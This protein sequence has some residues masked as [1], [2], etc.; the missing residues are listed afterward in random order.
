MYSLL[1]KSAALIVLQLLFVLTINAQQDTIVTHSG[2]VIYGKIL[3]ES[4]SIV[5]YRFSSTDGNVSYQSLSYSSIKRIGYF[6][7]KA[8]DSKHD[9]MVG[10]GFGL[11]YGGIGLNASWYISK[12][13]RIMISG[14][15]VAGE[16]GF[17][18]G[19]TLRSLRLQDKMK[20]IPV[21]IVMYGYNARAFDESLKT[22]KL[23]YGPTI[24]GGLEYYPN[25]AKQR[26]WTFL[27]LLPFRSNEEI[28]RYQ[29]EWYLQ[30]KELYHT[31]TW[32]GISVGYNF[33]VF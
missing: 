2:E 8:L 11:Y 3:N 32:F 6:I 4:D 5:R 15:H 14:G 12:N 23:F 29:H 24:G 16:N 30:K 9:F 28:D 25:E 22:I 10:P 20:V 21:A 31:S 26:Y 7:S 1:S 19:I 18:A 27:L 33:K 13:A 17:N